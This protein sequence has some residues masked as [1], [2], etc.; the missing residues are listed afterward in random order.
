MSREIVQNLKFR[1][2]TLDADALAALV[3]QGYLQQRRET[4]FSQK[5][6]FSPS[7]IGYGH[8]T[9]PRYWYLAFTGGEAVDTADALGIANMMN[10]SSAHDR[11]QKIFENTGIL[12]DTEVEI[13]L[14][15]PPVRGFI[16]LLIRWNGEVVVGEIK[17]TRQEAFLFRQSSMKPSANHL[18]QVLI[19]MDATK[20][21][22]GFLFYE[23]KNTQEYVIIPVEMNE[24]NQEILANA[25]D[26]MR[27]T[28]ASWENKELP[29]R[30]FQKRNKICQNCPLFDS[31]WNELPEGVV[32]LPVMEVPKV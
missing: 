12:V 27:K 30:P 28:Y 5:K 23:N 19:Y 21:S 2:T 32:G 29:K 1:N 25:Y 9:C 26:W 31:C 11:L 20:K 22:L 13:R 7:S 3:E 16:D 17:T 4:K 10:G 24:K 18:F 6:T 15:D 8:G 14:S